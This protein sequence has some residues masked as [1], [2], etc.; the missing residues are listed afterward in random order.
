MSFFRCGVKT[1]SERKNIAS[2][3][4]SVIVKFANWKSTFEDKQ[5]EKQKNIKQLFF[6]VIF[7]NLVPKFLKLLIRK[8]MLNTHLSKLNFQRLN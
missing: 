8:M 4:S 1:E 3:F 6:F 5:Q 7:Q 2:G